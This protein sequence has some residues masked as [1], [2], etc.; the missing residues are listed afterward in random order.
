MFGIGTKEIII[1][2]IVL[3]FLF[4]AKRIPE[5]A[6]AIGEGIRSLRK[7]VDVKEKDDSKNT[8]KGK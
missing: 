1:I 2:A 3:V 8:K 7:A 6:K 4:G 5:L